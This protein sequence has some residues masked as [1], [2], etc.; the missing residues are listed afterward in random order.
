MLSSLNK[1]KKGILLILISAL[2]SALGQAAWKMNQGVISWEL[3]IGFLL[4]GSGAVLM[5]YAFRFGSLS[6]L[7]PFLS[8][9]YIFA[10]F[11]G[12]LF[13]NEMLSFSHI[14]S[15]VVI[16]VGVL[17]IGGGGD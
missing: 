1:N 5:L 7:Q 15:V 13:F 17:L 14:L 12:V 4:Y 6:V 3:I 16:I 11:I 2:L 8:L 10:L 9:G